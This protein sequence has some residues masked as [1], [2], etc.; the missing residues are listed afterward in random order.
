MWLT[1]LKDIYFTAWQA[2]AFRGATR[3]S[4][5]EAAV[6]R[7]ARELIIHSNQL[8]YPGGMGR[9][10]ITT[11]TSL[12]SIMTTE[13]RIFWHTYS[14]ADNPWVEDRRLPRRMP[15]SSHVLSR[16]WHCI[17]SGSRRV[18]DRTLTEQRSIVLLDQEID[19]LHWSIAGDKIA[20][21]RTAADCR[22]L[23][24]HQVARDIVFYAH[25]LLHGHRW[26]V[27][28]YIANKHV[29]QALTTQPFRWFKG[30]CRTIAQTLVRI[31]TAAGNSAWQTAALT[32]IPPSPHGSELTEYQIW[33]CYRVAVRQLNT[34][35][36]GRELDPSCSKLRCCRREKETM[37]HIFWTCSCAQACWQ[38]FICHW[39]SERWYLGHL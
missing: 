39:T 18:G 14:W 6:H 12:L 29:Q 9:G 27:P 22:T 10:A 38:K 7:R 21:Q 30:S 2:W 34:Y 20:D 5:T 31:E 11:N 17:D 15:R 26:S 3:S 24:R 4:R 1:K 8:D 35:F 25:P 13:E 28:D 36:P 16:S 19:C 37:E 32:Q 23:L 33:V